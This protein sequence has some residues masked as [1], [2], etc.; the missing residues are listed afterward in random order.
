MLG[1]AY[2]KLGQP[3]KAIEAFGRAAKAGHAHAAKNLETLQ[4]YMEYIAE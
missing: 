3:E 4:A 2:V 1:A